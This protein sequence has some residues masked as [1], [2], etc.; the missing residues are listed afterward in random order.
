MAK[1]LD[2]GVRRE[3]PTGAV[4]DI[5]KGKGRCDLLPLA[6]C[7]DLLKSHTLACIDMFMVTR[8][9]LELFG[10]IESFQSES[11]FPSLACVVLEA[12]RQF[13]DG[14]E[15]YGWRNWEKGLPIDA[16][17]DSGVRHYLKWCDGQT[18]E[19]HDRAFIWNMLCAIWT[20]QNRGD[21]PLEENT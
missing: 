13:E 21:I 19:P 8:D 6:V 15:K 17:M 3:F 10:A 20:M 14:A 1:L 18:D 4:R 2:S 9:E 7:A 11:K 12:A 16:F 5:Q